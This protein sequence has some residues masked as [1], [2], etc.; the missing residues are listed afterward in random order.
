MA[1]GILTSLIIMT[2]GVTN[3]ITVV[4]ACIPKPVVRGLQL[5]LGLSMFT[6][7]IAMLPDDQKVTWDRDSW[8]H[9]DGYLV[10]TIC[11]IVCVATAKSR[12]FPTAFAIFAIG[13]IIASIRMS[14]EGQTFEFGIAEM[15]TVVPTRAEWKKGFISAAIPQI[16]TTLLNTSAASQC[17]KRSAYR[18]ENF[19][20]RC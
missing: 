10:G 20:A 16:P 19:P 18:H 14:D 4:D 12:W 11:M 5:G 13:V 17:G 6:K 2:L 15:H 9:W 8:M 3:L 7:A 1:A